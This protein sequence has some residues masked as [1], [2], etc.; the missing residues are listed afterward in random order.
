M[1]CSSSLRESAG[2]FVSA[3]PVSST[4]FPTLYPEDGHFFVGNLDHISRTLGNRPYNIWMRLES[5]A[6]AAN[7]LESLRAPAASSSPGR[8]T[9]AGRRRS[10]APTRSGPRS[11]V[12]CRSVLWSRRSFQGWRSCCTLCSQLRLRILQFGLLRAIGLSTAQITAVV[13]FEKLFLVLLAAVGGTLIGALTAALFVPPAAD[14][15]GRPRFDAAVYRCPGLGPG[16]KD[17]SRFRGDGG[18]HAG[19][20]G[21]PAAPAAHLRSHQVRRA[22]IELLAA[23]DRPRTGNEFMGNR[24]LT[25]ARK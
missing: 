19:D 6:S 1:T 18:R 10:G 20:S 4:I 21:R 8:P 23:G 16:C 17:L 5:D 24:T 25:Q 12:S 2:P 11:S 3:S 13:V 22:G 15:S 7:I 14:R 9:A